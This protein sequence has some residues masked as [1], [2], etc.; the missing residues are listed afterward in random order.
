ME[1]A[2]TWS[3]K[4][5][6]AG[7]SVWSSF[8]GLLGG[9]SQ[10][11]STSSETKETEEA[12]LIPEDVFPVPDMEDTRIKCLEVY[13]TEYLN[14][15]RSGHVGMSMNLDHL[16]RCV[17]HIYGCLYAPW[18][19]DGTP[20]RGDRMREWKCGNLKEVSTITNKLYVEYNTNHFISIDLYIG[21]KETI[22]LSS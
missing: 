15:F 17:D 13:M 20:R 3:K 5:Q 16:I 19:Q 14:V 8:K 2:K 10:S 11:D 7:S 1:E 12:Q 22:A 18:I 6:Q 4:L 9:S 21:A